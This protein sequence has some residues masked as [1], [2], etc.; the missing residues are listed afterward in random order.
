MPSALLTRLRR[1]WLSLLCM[2]ALL[3]GLPVSCGA[4][5]YKERELLFRIEPGTASWYRGLP[6]ETFRSSTSSL[7]IS[8]PDKPACL[9][10]AGGP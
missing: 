7:P 8:R 10:V 6:Q 1:R 4:L 3:V 2:A 5:K 9:V